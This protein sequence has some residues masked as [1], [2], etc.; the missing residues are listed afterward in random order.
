MTAGRRRR[1]RRRRRRQSTAATMRMGTW[2][3]DACSSCGPRKALLPVVNPNGAKD[4]A[5]VEMQ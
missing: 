3:A 1:K 4:I 2:Q 5:G